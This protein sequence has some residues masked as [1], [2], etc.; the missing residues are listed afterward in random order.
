MKFEIWD[1]DE[2]KWNILFVDFLSVTE[3]GYFFRKTVSTEGR[4]IEIDE[5]YRKQSTT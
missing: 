4:L 5:I 1:N 2:K 3:N